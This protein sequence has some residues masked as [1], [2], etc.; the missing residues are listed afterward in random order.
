MRQAD[1]L[2]LVVP[3][4]PDEGSVPVEN[5]LAATA[6]DEVALVCVHEV[7]AESLKWAHELAT[8]RW[9]RDN[10]EELRVDDLA[11]AEVSERL[12]A[13]EAALIEAIAPFS[14]A[15]AATARRRRRGARGGSPTGGPGARVR[16]V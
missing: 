15:A 1:G 14:A 2:V 7:T 11:R 12:A 10:C 16:E 3:I 8:W 13:A 5:A 6:T 9:I 4:H